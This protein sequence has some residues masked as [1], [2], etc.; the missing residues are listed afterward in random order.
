MSIKQKLETSISKGPIQSDPVAT[1]SHVAYTQSLY[2]C[3]REK[4][5]YMNSTQYIPH[6][7]ILSLWE[8]DP[9]GSASDTCLSPELQGHRNQY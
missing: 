3:A 7:S 2:T 1:L 6:P 4:G 5:Q 8:G 9:W